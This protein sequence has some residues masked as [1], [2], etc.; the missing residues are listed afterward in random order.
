MKGDPSSRIRA[1]GD[2]ANHYGLAAVPRELKS[3]ER[4]NVCRERQERENLHMTTREKGKESSGR[5]E[6]ESLWIKTVERRI[7]RESAEREG[8]QR[9]FKRRQEG[10]RGTREGESL[11]T[12]L[13]EKVFVKGQKREEETVKEFS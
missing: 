4:G 6:R 9:V 13:R 5:T 1:R 10:E 7:V 3:H 12:R 2:G 11:P 8:K